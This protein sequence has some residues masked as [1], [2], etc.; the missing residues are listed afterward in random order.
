MNDQ[1]AAQLLRNIKLAYPN[2]YRDLDRKSAD[3]T[4]KM[5]AVSF[6]E[7]PFKVMEM[8]FNRFRMVSRYPPTV[9][10]MVS[11]LERM[12]YRALE[13]AR[14]HKMLGNEE[15]AKRWM[16]VVNFTDPY[17]RENIEGGRINGDDFGTPGNWLDG[18]DGLPQ[19]GPGPAEAGPGDL[20]G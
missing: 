5:W 15:R 10:E 4:V 13:N 16:N 20:G 2:A 1:E 7:V 11:E 18:G 6:P 19:L 17:K 9:A 12:H 8:A 3:A 14:L